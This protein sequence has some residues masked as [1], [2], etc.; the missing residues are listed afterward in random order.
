MGAVV[1]GTP[2]RMQ[3]KSDMIGRTI[4]HDKILPKLGEAGVGVGCR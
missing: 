1:V 2:G 4:S 3:F